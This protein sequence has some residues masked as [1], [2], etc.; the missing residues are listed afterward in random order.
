MFIVHWGATVAGFET[1]VFRFS[2]LNF[3]RLL[4]VRC[5]VPCCALCGHVMKVASVSKET[6]L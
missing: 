3:G 2:P 1:K 4:C 6:L 5:R